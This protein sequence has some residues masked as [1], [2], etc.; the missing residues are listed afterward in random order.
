MLGERAPGRPAALIGILVGGLVATLL[1]MPASWLAHGVAAASQGQVQLSLPRGTLWQ[2]SAEL[3]LSGGSGSRDS[4]RL[5]GRVHWRLS[6]QWQ[7]PSFLSSA[8]LGLQLRADCCTPEPLRLALQPAW[9]G[10]RV[11][12]ADSASIWPTALLAGLG[13]PWNTLQPSGTAHLVPRQWQARWV[14][15][16]WQFSGQAELELRQLASGLSTLRP[17]G[18]YRLQVQGDPSDPSGQAL[19][20]T[21]A[22]LQGELQLSGKGQW[23]GTRLRFAGEARAEAGKEAALANFLNVVGRRDGARSII[24]L[25]PAP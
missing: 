8:A 14:D 22:T 4:L 23:S 7:G 11:A 1:W 25:G 12:L 2:G 9:P 3:V 17:L 21:L 10:W 13:T 5:P 16:R 18:S 6:P 15:G 20:L 24:S 19:E